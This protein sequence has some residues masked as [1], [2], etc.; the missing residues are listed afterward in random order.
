M[1]RNN[2]TICCKRC[3]KIYDKANPDEKYWNAEPPPLNK[4][5]LCDPD[6]VNEML[7]NQEKK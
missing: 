4:I 3:L 2:K 7:E 6:D 5:I 1:K